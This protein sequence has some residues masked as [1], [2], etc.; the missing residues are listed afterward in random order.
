MSNR[1]RENVN[2]YL[3]KKN[4]RPKSAS[5]ANR[6]SR[7][8]NIINTSVMPPRKLQPMAFKSA[9]ANEMCIRLAVNKLGKTKSLGDLYTRSKSTKG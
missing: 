6:S 3:K 2:A 5:L 8:V 1:V 7:K 4:Q 9:S